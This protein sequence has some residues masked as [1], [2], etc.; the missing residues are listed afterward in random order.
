[1]VFISHIYSNAK[2]QRERERERE[3]EHLEALPEFVFTEAGV[4]PFRGK[5]PPPPPHTHSATQ[6]ERRLYTVELQWLEHLWDH[7]N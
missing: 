3:R 4:V 6:S 2:I 5:I 1:M 7:E